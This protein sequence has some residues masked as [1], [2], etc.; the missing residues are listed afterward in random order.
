MII[1]VYMNPTIDKTVYLSNLTLG[2]TNRPD[3]VVTDGAGKAVNV[4]AVLRELGRDVKVEGLLYRSDG[5]LIKERLRDCGAKYDFIE[6]HG[7]SRTNTKIFD[8]VSKEITEI[9]EGGQGVASAVL[10]DALQKIEDSAKEGDVVVLTGSLPPDCDKG[11]Y[12]E[13]VKR[14]NKKGARCVLDA[15]GEALR[16]GVEKKP[17]FIKP[18]LDELASLIGSRPGSLD[19][20]KR[21]CG[22]IIEKGV[23]LVGVSMGGDGAI[24]CDKKS[25]YFAKPVKVNVLSTVGAGD[26]MVAGI[27][28]YM[29][30]GV[31][32]ALRSGVAAAAGSV[33]LEGTSLCTKAL[34]EKYYKMVEIE[35]V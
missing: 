30:Q 10:K 27:V 28:A 29:E 33:T 11:F 17:Y 5:E 18:N 6:L 23:S 26:S 4:A 14:L 1:C 19:E 13:L 21:A 12:A 8:R 9:N 25:A 35:K 24:L 7:T 15:D 34:F 20:V 3:K 16:L 2:G 31:E 32:E 22:S